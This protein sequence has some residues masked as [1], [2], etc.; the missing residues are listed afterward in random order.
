MQPDTTIT[1]PHCCDYYDDSDGFDDS[2]EF[3][4]F[5]EFNK[6][7]Q[8]PRQ[9]KHASAVSHGKYKKKLQRQNVKEMTVTKHVLPKRESDSDKTDSPKELILNV[10]VQKKPKHL[11]TQERGQSRANITKQRRSDL[12]EKEVHIQKNQN[13]SHDDY[14]DY[15]DDPDYIDDLD[16]YNSSCGYSCYPDSYYDDDYD[17]DDYGYD[18]GFANYYGSTFAQGIPVVKMTLEQNQS[19]PTKKTMREIL[20]FVGSGMTTDEAFTFGKF[21]MR[22]LPYKRRE[23]IEVERNGQKMSVNT[24]DISDISVIIKKYQEWIDGEKDCFN[25]K[26]DLYYY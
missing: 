2:D 11:V 16:F 6:F 26:D 21:C 18:G 20:D 15:Y 22:S 13:D 5:D 4:E 25:E 17:D 9:R 24:Y 10:N 14:Y 23:K 1:I 19:L 12:I 8:N 3:D 7:E